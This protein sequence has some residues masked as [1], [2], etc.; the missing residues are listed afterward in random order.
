MAGELS[1]EAAREI[2]QLQKC[3][4]RARRAGNAALEAAAC[5]RLGQ[6]LAAHGRFREALEQHR[7]ELALLEAAGDALGSA[8][9]HRRVG[10]SLAELQRFPQALEHQLQ[11]LSLARSLADPVEQQRA[12]ATIGRTFLFMAE[13]PDVPDIP[14]IPEF[15][16]F[17]K[18]PEAAQE[19]EGTEGN[20]GIRENLGISGAATAL[21]R[22]LQAF[23]N[24]LHV[25]ET[26]L[27]G[28][29]P[30]REL[31]RMRS[32]L[33]LNLGLARESLG[34]PG[35]RCLTL[36]ADSLRWARESQSLEDQFRAHLNLGLLQQ[37]L[38]NLPES[39]RSLGRA[40]HCAQQLGQPRLQGDAQAHL[41]QVLLALGDFEG[42]RRELRRAL[43]LGQTDSADGQRARRGLRHASRVCRCLAA[44][45][46]ADPAVPSESLALCERLGDSLARLGHFQRAAEFYQKQLAL[47]ESLELPGRD[48]AVIH[49]SLATTFRD[50]G[51][52]SRALEHFQRELELRKGEPLE[53][54]GA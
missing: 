2:R 8:V 30:G 49:V 5:N 6:L 20:S 35:P 36:L 24:S 29:V 26:Q 18:I 7:A 17:P 52:H 21:R 45:A 14:D 32:R 33:C 48:L 19:A 40:R 34:C 4:E 50:L 28:A 3:Q 39:L 16:E 27:E 15:P 22:A 11:H 38:R 31:A 42:A 44:L 13:S 47:A 43:S 1:A 46:R 12:W 54:G 53:V 9:A 25:L 23:H 37:R 51:Q 41:G 10:E